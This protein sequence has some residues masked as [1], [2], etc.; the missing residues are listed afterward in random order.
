MKEKKNINNKSQNIYIIKENVEPTDKSFQ[1]EWRFLSIKTELYNKKQNKNTA[2]KKSL[3]FVNYLFFFVLFF[4]YFRPPYS[5]FDK[6]TCVSAR[7]VW[8]LFEFLK[9]FY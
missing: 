7:V 1:S 4:F 8:N 9:I 5:F 6:L 3:K 2:V